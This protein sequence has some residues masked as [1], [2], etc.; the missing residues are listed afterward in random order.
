MHS[1]TGKDSAGKSNSQ[2]R[3][4]IVFRFLNG[5]SGD[6]IIKFM[7]MVFENFKHFVTGICN[8]GLYVWYV[9]KLCA[10]TYVCYGIF[11]MHD[12]TV[13]HFF[14]VESIFTKLSFTEFD[15]FFKEFHKVHC[16]YVQ[17]MT[18][19]WFLSSFIDDVLAMVCKTEKELDLSKMIPLRKITG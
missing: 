5:C 4:S 6:E 2:F 1:K 9:Y 17:P 8:Y 11:S 10:H 3:R 14:L 18:C 12:K 15:E 19:I 7:E 16:R 13:L